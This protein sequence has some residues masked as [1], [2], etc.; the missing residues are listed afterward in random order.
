M[1]KVLKISKSGYYNWLH[2]GMSKRWL[3]DQEL[4][5]LIEQILEEHHIRLIISDYNL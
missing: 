5:D 4:G 1:C 2:S 3:Y